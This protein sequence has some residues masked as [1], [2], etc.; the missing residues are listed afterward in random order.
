MSFLKTC[1]QQWKWFVGTICLTVICAI[2]FLLVVAPKY[3]RSAAILIKD[4]NGGGG[5]LS[6]MASNM[7]MLA[8]IAGLN[9]TSNVENEM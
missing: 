9:I 1:L 7:G 4:E 3:E 8:G 6:S 5:L 2:L